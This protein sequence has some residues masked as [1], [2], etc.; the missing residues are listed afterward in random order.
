MSITWISSYEETVEFSKDGHTYPQYKDVTSHRTISPNNCQARGLVTGARESSSTSLYG[1]GFMFFASNNTAF[2]LQGL[3]EDEDEDGVTWSGNYNVMSLSGADTNSDVTRTGNG[4]KILALANKFKEEYFGGVTQDAAS[5]KAYLDEKYGEHD[6]YYFD[7]SNIVDTGLHAA[8]PGPSFYTFAKEVTSQAPR[9]EPLYA[10]EPHAFPSWL[11]F[12]GKTFGYPADLDPYEPDPAR[13]S[14]VG[15]DW[16]AMEPIIAFFIFGE[17]MKPTRLQFDVYVN[18]RTD[19]TVAI[20]WQEIVQD[21]ETSLQTVSPIV[22]TY[23]TA[24][25]TSQ[26][27]II[28]VDGL[29]VPNDSEWYVRRHGYSFSATGYEY[30][31]LSEFNSITSQLSDFE[32]VVLYGLDGIANSQHYYLRFNQQLN[33]DNEPVLHW[34]ELYDVF[35]PREVNSVAD[36]IVNRLTPSEKDPSFSTVVVVHLGAAP[37]ETEDDEDDY[38]DG[39]DAGGDPGGVYPPGGGGVPDFS[40]YEPTGFPGDSV[41]TRTYS[42]SDSVLQ[43]IGTKLWTQSYFDVLKV[44]SNP[45]ENI[46]SCK[47]FPFSL[48]GTTS[49]VTIGDVAMGINGS[50]ISSLYTVTIGSYTYSPTASFLSCSPYTTIKLHLPYCGIIQL[51]ASEIYKRKLTVKYAIDLITGDCIAMIYLDADTNNPGIPYLT[52]AGSCGVDIPLTASNRVQTEMKATSATM[53]AVVGASAHLMGGDVMGAASAASSMANVAGMDYTS[54]RSTSHSPACM[55]KMSRAVYIEIIS[56]AYDPEVYDNNGYK[57]R[58]GFPCH[59]YKTLSSLSGFVKCD[60]RTKLNFASTAEENRMI[61]QLLTEG[62]YV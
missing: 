52:I 62:V 39:T 12:N 24:M 21:E 33:Q 9:S 42:M 10:Q 56:P 44:Q 58:H 29:K 14:A 19:P 50:K 4:G 38:P 60:L 18:G 23:P 31:Y 15:Y 45:I 16:E 8:Y 47:W 30:P 28:T 43:N 25:G 37:D 53:S 57:S 13:V 1:Y 5:I 34:G 49:E 48:T 61:E 20:R 40:G 3:E 59:K 22:W 55:S 17:E 36:I 41:L 6:Y 54:Q 2:S 51:D 32:K 11:T 27:P 35:V 26:E 46:V 7:T